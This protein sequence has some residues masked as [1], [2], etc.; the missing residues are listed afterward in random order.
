MKRL[1]ILG[2]TGSIGRNA[3]DIVSQYRDLFKVAVLTAGTNVDLL[4]KQIKS[5]SPEV[6]ALANENAA[7][8]LRKRM[9]KRRASSL[10]ILSG[11]NGVA[12]AAAYK[13]SDFVLSAIVGAAGL[14][15]TLSAIRSRKTIG[16]ANKESLVMAGR[17]VT[18]ESK[19]YKVKILPVDSE[20]SAI[21]QCIEGY[22][23][24]DVKKIILTASGGNAY[25]QGI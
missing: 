9:G 10:D 12:E 4:E 3:L 7:G 8:E 20:H 15:P 17:I 25:E 11:K 5:F 24:S 2:S 18:D 16:L 22:E 13:D 23:I 21:F 6:V 19:K 1:T 14:V